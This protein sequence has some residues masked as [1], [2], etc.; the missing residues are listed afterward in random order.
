MAG[1]HSPRKA[2]LDRALRLFQQGYEHQMSGELDEAAALYEASIGLFPTAEAHTF[3]GV[4]LFVPGPPGRR[5]PAV[6]EGDR[7]RPGVRQLLQRHRRVSD[8]AGQARRSH[9]MAGARAARGPVRELPLPVVQPRPRPCRHGLLR[10]CAG[11]LPRVARDRAGLRAGHRRDAVRAAED[12][13]TAYSRRTTR[14]ERVRRHHHR[15][16]HRRLPDRDPGG[17]AR[18]QGRRGRAAEDPGRHLPEL[19]MHPDEGAAR[20]R[21]RAEDRAG[22]EGMGP[23]P[24]RPARAHRHEPGADPQGQDRHHPH[25]RRR[26]PLQEE[27]HHLDQGQRAGSPARARSR[28]PATSRRR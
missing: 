15:G 5:H 9:P 28:S 1:E 3:L 16:R 20:A 2:L 17:A 11:V 7:G 10:P 14:G 4:D 24:R 13:L 23:H 18:P 8:R 25:A 26:V 12:P 21:A 6:P 27:Q 19:G 22:V